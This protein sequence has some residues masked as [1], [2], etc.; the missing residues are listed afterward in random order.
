VTAL[1]VE[2]NARAYEPV[3]RPDLN[4]LQSRMCADRTRP[5]TNDLSVG[6]RK[7]PFAQI[8]VHSHPFA[9]IRDRTGGLYPRDKGQSEHREL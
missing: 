6:D 5:R 2:L 7:K 4:G 3:S 9:P 8:R 1:P